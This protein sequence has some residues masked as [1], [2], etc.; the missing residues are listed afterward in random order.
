MVPPAATAAVIPP[1]TAAVIPPTAAVIPPA[2]AVIKS[3]N[4]IV[5]IWITLD[6]QAVV[7]D[8]N[9]QLSRAGSVHRDDNQEI[10]LVIEK[11]F[12]RRATQIR[13]TWCK[14]HATE[15]HI[16]QGKVTVDEKLGT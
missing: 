16:E 1:A 9:K 5:P 12:L 8:S 15:E 3:E 13:V 14:G 4:R 10:L 7:K 6:N 2:A 11:Q